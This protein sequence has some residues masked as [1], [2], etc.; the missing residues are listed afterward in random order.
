M[1]TLETLIKLVGVKLDERRRFLQRKLSAEQ[2]LKDAQAAL[3][4]QVAEERAAA[5]SLEDASFAYGAYAAQAAKKQKELDA[6]I[7]R[8]GKAVDAARDH[9]AEAFEEQK[10]YEIT[11]DRRRLA[12]AQEQAQQERKELDELGLERHRRRPK[13]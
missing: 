12:E 13:P 11:L 8:A 9:L 2:E 10:R 6:A 4:K 3:E 7:A 5:A 1:K